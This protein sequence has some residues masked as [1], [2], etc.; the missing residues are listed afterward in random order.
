MI[1]GI[2][3][4]LL[5]AA[6]L[7]STA[8]AQTDA[9]KAFRTGAALFERG[10]IR[11]SIAHFETAVRLS[12]D[13][14]SYVKALGVAYAALGEYELAEPFLG[15]ACELDPKLEHACYYHG[16]TLYAL[17]R[18]EP[19]IAS[20][21]AA[22]PHDAKPW[23]IHLALGQAMEALGRAEPAERHFQQSIREHREQ[24]RPEDD[25]RIHY[26]V[27]LFRQARMEEAVRQ[28]Q[29]AAKARPDSARAHFELGRALAQLEKPEDAARSLKRAVD[30]DPKYAAAHLLLG[31]VYRQLGQHDKAEKHT[32]LGR[33]A[34]QDGR[35]T[36]PARSR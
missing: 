13:T 23:R 24:G 16:R 27:F 28:F 4:A 6:L 31:K 20:L 29:D 7:A 8:A 26:G 10:K 9:E 1:R 25:P 5:L 30:L 17:N 15:H 22:L 35:L 32:R 33:A 2:V 3:V 34:E 18:F 11:E 21:Q 19:A 36:A 12:P 14:L